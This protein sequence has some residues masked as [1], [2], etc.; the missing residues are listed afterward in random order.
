[1]QLSPGNVYVSPADLN[2]EFGKIQEPHVPTIRYATPVFHRDGARAGIVIFNLY[3]EPFL[4]LVQQVESGGSTLALADGAGYYMVHPETER[5]WGSPADLRSGQ[6]ALIDYTKAWE[7]MMTMDSGVF[8]PWREQFWPMIQGLFQ[9]G[10]SSAADDYRV[11]VCQAV[12]P[13]NETGPRWLLMHDAPRVTMF[14]TV[15]EFRITAVL[16]LTFTVLLAVGMAVSLASNLIAPI[17]RLTEVVRDY[18][19]GRT[20]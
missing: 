17:L 7:G 14:A 5:E 19:Y 3:A 8:A 16:I 9:I 10:G 18:G 2:R 1:M 15:S 12:N 11:L 4:Q 6:S 20:Q 13:G